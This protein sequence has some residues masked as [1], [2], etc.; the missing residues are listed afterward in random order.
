MTHKEAISPE[1][2]REQCPY[3]MLLY[4]SQESTQESSLA[5]RLQRNLPFYYPIVADLSIKQYSIL[6]LPSRATWATD[7]ARVVDGTLIATTFFR[8]CLTETLGKIGFNAGQLLDLLPPI[9]I[10]HD[11]M[12]QIEN[13]TIVP[14]GNSPYVLHGHTNYSE[15]GIPSNGQE[16]PI[17]ASI[18]GLTVSDIKRGRETIS[19]SSPHIDR[20]ITGFASG[21]KIDMWLDESIGF[22]QNIIP[23]LFPSHH[24]VSTVV[25]PSETDLNV[26]YLQ[27][28]G[29]V[30]AMTSSRRSISPLVPSLEQ[31]Q[32]PIVAMGID[33]KSNGGSI[34]CRTM[35]I[36]WRKRE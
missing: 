5:D 8:D 20:Y 26:R 24:D 22:L 12:P 33:Q 32:I 28:P 3:G 15:N 34:K 35:V 30:F 1:R 31:A 2:I 27:Y 13:G 29:G 16:I 19:V 10:S 18:I 17:D 23:D 25:V 21:G 7:H 11:L 14:I 36:P 4:H 6:E 9:T